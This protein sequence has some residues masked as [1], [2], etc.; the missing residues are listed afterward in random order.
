MRIWL[1][2]ALVAA[3]CSPVAGYAIIRAAWPSGLTRAAVTRAMP[4]VAAIAPASRAVLAVGEGRAAATI[5]G[6]S[7]P[8]PKPRAIAA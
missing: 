6:A 5:S 3:S 8:G 4:G 1:T 2:R 7:K